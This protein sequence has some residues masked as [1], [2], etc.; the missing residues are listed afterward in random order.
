MFEH[1]NVLYIS[2]SP[3]LQLLKSC[4]IS[5]HYQPRRVQ[6]RTV[7]CENNNHDCDCA[8]LIANCGANIVVR[9]VRWLQVISLSG[10]CRHTNTSSPIS[11][12]DPEW[13]NSGLWSPGQRG[14]DGTLRRRFCMNFLATWGILFMLDIKNV[15]ILA[16][17]FKSPIQKHPCSPL[18]H[19]II[20]LC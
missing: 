13:G 6:G 4:V 20:Y 14:S 7:Q 15:Y 2:V 8:E 9:P 19:R 1:K 11:S 3:Y 12:Y 17:T 18:A 5:R 16:E 10:D